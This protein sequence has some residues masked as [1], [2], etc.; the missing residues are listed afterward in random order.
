[1]TK[2][3]QSAKDESGVT[4]PFVIAHSFEL[5]HSDFVILVHMSL[6][7]SLALD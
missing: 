7:W 2:E 3:A 1:M 6:R 4:M 5:G